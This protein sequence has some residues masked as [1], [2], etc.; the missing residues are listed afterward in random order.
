ME[1]PLVEVLREAMMNVSPVADKCLCNVVTQ[2]FAVCRQIGSVD[3][4]EWWLWLWL[5]ALRAVW[6]VPLVSPGPR[7][8]DADSGCLTA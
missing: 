1:G 3:R 8:Y 6:Q 2:I 7:R 4:A 5:C